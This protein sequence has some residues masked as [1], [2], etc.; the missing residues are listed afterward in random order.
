MKK[1][2]SNSNSTSNNNKTKQTSTVPSSNTCTLI[3]TSRNSV[4]WF[5]EAQEHILDEVR[6]LNQYK[7]FTEEERGKAAEQMKLLATSS[8]TKGI[9][10]TTLALHYQYYQTKFK[11]RSLLL[12]QVM[13][14]FL[15]TS[16]KG[17]PPIISV[18]GLLL[19]KV[20]NGSLAGSEFKEIFLYNFLQNL[21]QKDTLKITSIGGGPGNDASCFVVLYENYLKKLYQNNIKL[22]NLKIDCVLY[23]L[24]KSWKNY[25]DRLQ[26]IVNEEVMSLTFQRCDVTKDFEN[27]LNRHLKENVNEFDIFI[28]SY[29]CNETSYL[30]KQNDGIF[31]KNLF[32]NAKG[33]SIFVFVDVIDYSKKALLY[34]ENIVKEFQKKEE[35]QQYIYLSYWPNLSNL[36]AEV[37]VVIKHE[38]V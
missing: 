20:K 3:K 27:S 11:K 15:K 18:K 38:Q 31:W 2:K 21:L 26:L 25:L 4:N 28:F 12:Y 8:D 14:Y 10:F 29:V 32:E 6:K 34:I 30:C 9:K 35:N 16:F 22:D 36:Q 5:D 7:P 13:E 19:E 37:M 1:Q 23:D 24:E 17:L 33:N